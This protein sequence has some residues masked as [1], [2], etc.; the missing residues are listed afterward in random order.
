MS[1]SEK[2][3]RQD[4]LTVRSTRAVLDV[5]FL[6]K[7]LCVSSAKK[8]RLGICAMAVRIVITLDAHPRIKRSGV[9]SA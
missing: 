2:S 1:K 9:A 5:V 4:F 7:N 3:A 6:S 8:A